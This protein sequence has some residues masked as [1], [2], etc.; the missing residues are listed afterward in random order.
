MSALQRKDAFSAAGVG[1]G[2]LFSDTKTMTTG[3][4]LSQAPKPSLFGSPERKIF[5]M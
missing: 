2:G 1:T 5:T 4:F 3:S